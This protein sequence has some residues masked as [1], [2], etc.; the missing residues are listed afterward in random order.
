[1]SMLEP[2]NN[3]CFTLFQGFSDTSLTPK[4]ASMVLAR[5]EERLKR[6]I[7][8]DEMQQGRLASILVPS[9]YVLPTTVCLF[10]L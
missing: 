1:M 10:K 3:Y 5:A 2:L 6:P 7:S 4:E 8:M 9:D